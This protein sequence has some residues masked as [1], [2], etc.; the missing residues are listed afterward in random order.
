M[1]EVENNPATLSDQR[2]AVYPILK[3][4]RILLSQ[5]RAGTIKLRID[6]SLNLERPSY[7]GRDELTEFITQQHSRALRA[8]P[9]QISFLVLDRDGESLISD[10]HDPNVSRRTLLNRASDD[11]FA[12]IQNSGAYQRIPIK[13][14]LLQNTDRSN[15]ATV[16]DIFETAH[17][18][19]HSTLEFE[20][21][22]S[23]NGEPGGG[24]SV[25][26]SGFLNSPD[27]DRSA[28]SR[29]HLVGFIETP[30]MRHG[31]YNVNEVP[32][33]LMSIP[34]TEIT[35]DNLLRES[36]DQVTGATLL[37]PPVTREIFYIEDDSP[38]FSSIN[39][40]PYAGPAHYHDASNPADGYIG[41]MAGHTVD[42][43][44]PKLSVRSVPNLK[45]SVE[46]PPWNSQPVSPSIGQPGVYQETGESLGDY[47]DSIMAS[48]GS[49]DP[50]QRGARLVAASVAAAT[51]SNRAS[52]V[53]P[54]SRKHVWITKDQNEDDEN[55]DSS[56]NCIIGV[57]FL[58]ILEHYSPFG[59]L[60]TH[61][62][63]IA[64]RESSNNSPDVALAKTML[65]R[66]M[67]NSRILDMSIVRRR[68]DQ[69]PYNNN[70]QDTKTYHD[71]EENQKNRIIV[72]AFDSPGQSDRLVPARWATAEVE[73]V[74]VDLGQPRILR[75]ESYQ[76]R[77][78]AS[79]ETRNTYVADEIYSTRSFL[80]R[81]YELF[82]NLDYGKYTYDIDLIVLDGSKSLVNEFKRDL[83]TSKLRLEKLLET[84]STPVIRTEQGRFVSG[85][86]DYHNRRFHEVES[87]LRDQ[88]V[89]A[90]LRL[91]TD[92]RNSVVLMTGVDPFPR[93]RDIEMV[94][95]A[96]DP[97]RQTTTI[98]NLNYLVVES[99]KIINSLGILLQEAF[100]ESGEAASNNAEEVH[101]P[102]ATGHA[103]PII[104][105][106]CNTGIVHDAS[107]TLKM[108]ADYGIFSTRPGD[109]ALNRFLQSARAQ[110]LS[111]AISDVYSG[112]GSIFEDMGDFGG[113]FSNPRIPNFNT[114]DL[115]S[116]DSSVFMPIEFSVMQGRRLEVIPGAPMQFTR[117]NPEVAQTQPPRST[118]SMPRSSNISSGQF[119]PRKSIPVKPVFAA[120]ALQR[121][122]VIKINKKDFDLMDLGSQSI[123]EAKILTMM[124]EESHTLGSAV[125]SPAFD[126]RFLASTVGGM[127]NTFSGFDISAS[128]KDITTAA[129]KSVAVDSSLLSD[130]IKSSLVDTVI[131]SQT[132]D[133][134]LRKVDENY[135]ELLAIK[136][137]LKGLYGVFNRLVSITKISFP[138]SFDRERSKSLF[139]NGP[140][141]NLQKPKLEIS[142]TPFQ[143]KGA[144]FV[145]FSKTG[146]SKMYNPSGALKRIADLSKSPV[147]TNDL[148]VVKLF[149]LEQVGSK[150]NIANVNNALMM[151]LN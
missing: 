68:L 134:F 131:E 128:G 13:D 93:A 58:E 14:V 95:S 57:K 113:R 29:L 75:D 106:S 49:N 43:M 78:S 20:V 64:S 62:R 61:F 82:Y 74:R 105:V 143:K 100:L 32:Q 84:L 130:G 83:I 77:T 108:V 140:D 17:Y 34:V 132:E 36:T 5:P 7:S 37:R 80:L 22:I 126:A 110:S 72:Q 115:I 89:S 26:G 25:F 2:A 146:D 42:N 111:G 19:V 50:V 59:R 15:Y 27:Y 63:E 12:K 39:L 124:Q 97:A 60:I 9:A 114:A 122:S 86:Y 65:S 101:V 70:D 53:E 48:R 38:E 118:Y 30:Y 91:V 1:S 11:R 28:L 88:W 117:E 104:Q 142:Q 94:V 54:W 79:A 92:S 109:G 52:F 51:R 98:E 40:R 133:E 151:E 87:S 144:K 90:A 149:K 35:Y 119:A 112:L 18:E 141:K 147:K 56:Y 66:F 145:E 150:D 46:A 24:G 85:M 3:T 16:T 99:E 102:N 139:E 55:L 76:Q 127:T 31:D 129:L 8:K 73:E 47:V 148:K 107:D 136:S 137:N 121:G 4:N 103:A 67:E 125:K 123:K 138:S 81:D 23:P 116:A 6:F 21:E 33:E 120:N 44:G 135:K 41:W 45:V 96:A 69:R 71:F 10:L